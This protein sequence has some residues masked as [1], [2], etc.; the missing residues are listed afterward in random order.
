[1]IKT[2][3][4]LAAGRGERLRPYTDHTPKPLLPIDGQAM[5]VRL[6]QRL[7]RAGIERCIINICYLAEQFIDALGDGSALGLRI[8]WSREAALLGAGGSLIHARALLG[9]EPFIVVSGDI[10]C[11]Y[12]FQTLVAQDLRA[13]RR[14]VHAVLVPNAVYYPAGDWALH[15]GRLAL[16]P[17]H[18]KHTFSAIAVIDPQLL[19]RRL[20]STRS[21]TELF[22]PAIQQ[23]QAS[24]ELF[25]GDYHNVGTVADYELLTMVKQGQA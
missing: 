3:M 15:E 5:I 9:D 8:I 24:G 7:Q 12:D 13:D 2:A 11:D 23:N 10:V 25:S 20:P 1:M 22:L 19:Q 17:N 16:T 14:L 21:I 18:E 6:L 4:V